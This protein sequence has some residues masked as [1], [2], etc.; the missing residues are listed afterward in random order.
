[1][2]D[3]SISDDPNQTSENEVKFFNQLILFFVFFCIK[4]RAEND[5]DEQIPINSN[6]ELVDYSTDAI[7]DQLEDLIPPKPK[8]Q[9][10]IAPDMFPPFV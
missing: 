1:M 6:E 5:E 2:T 9:P 10:I 8:I 3:P 7:N 4:L